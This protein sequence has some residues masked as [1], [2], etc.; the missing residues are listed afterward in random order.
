MQ[1]GR[2]CHLLYNNQQPDS[3]KRPFS[4]NSR[5]AFC[6]AVLADAIRQAVEDKRIVS[7]MFCGDANCNL[8][9]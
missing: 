5:I 7:F 6:K 3:G 1:C 8:L 2:A 9:H 4:K